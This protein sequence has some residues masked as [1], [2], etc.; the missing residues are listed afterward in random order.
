M[1]RFRL[2]Q[3]VSPPAVI[4]FTSATADDGKELIA[5]GLSY[6]YALTGYS[7]LFID[8]AL[9]NRTLAE[10]PRGLTITEIGREQSAT[11][12]ESGKLS[13]LSL[14]DLTLHRRT[15]LRSMKA[16][17]EIL[18]SKF[19]VIVISTEGEV[20]N[21][22]AEAIMATADAV[23]VTVAKGRRET[24]ADLQLA[25]ELELAGERFLGVIAVDPAVIAL[26]V[27]GRAHV[28]ATTLLD[29]PRER[30]R[31]SIARAAAAFKSRLSGGRDDGA[32]LS[33]SRTQPESG[34]HQ[35]SLVHAK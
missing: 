29:R 13:A 32:A 27:A 31:V 33:Q 2:E 26:N 23:L 14:N 22:F 6:S 10:P 4:A 30:K 20:A 9:A 16:A 1:L 28:P 3:Q 24:D 15:S 12:T 5:R 19:D 17:L 34:E 11:D 21:A 7:T 8:T 25:S 18:R 35:R